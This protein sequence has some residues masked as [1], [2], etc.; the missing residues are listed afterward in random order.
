MID[1]K[2]LSYQSGKCHACSSGGV[3]WMMG[4]T[5]ADGINE[6]DFGLTMKAHDIDAPLG[7]HAAL[8]KR[9]EKMYLGIGKCGGAAVIELGSSPFSLF[10]VPG[11]APS[12][13]IHFAGSWVHQYMANIDREECMQIDG[14]LVHTREDFYMCGDEIA[15]NARMR[16]TKIMK[17]VYMKYG[18]IITPPIVHLLDNSNIGTADPCYENSI[19]VDRGMIVAWIG[20]PLDK[21]KPPTQFVACRKDMPMGTGFAIIAELEGFALPP[22]IITLIDAF[23]P[24]SGIVTDASVTYYQHRMMTE[25]VSKYFG[26]PEAYPIENAY[27]V[28]NFPECKVLDPWSIDYIQL[29]GGKPTKEVNRFYIRHGSLGYVHNG[30]DYASLYAGVISMSRIVK[31]GFE[32]VRCSYGAGYVTVCVRNGSYGICERQYDDIL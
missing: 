19:F 28:L 4:G 18:H 17:G 2:K 14:R 25:A 16:P 5:W 29:S 3:R 27:G 31:H 12:A 21:L 26:I 30:I 1:V 6:Y 10:T 15:S 32:I 11:M 7:Y 8:I 13:P 22:E 20:G 9:G 24:R 23:V